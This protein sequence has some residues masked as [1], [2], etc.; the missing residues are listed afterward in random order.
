MPM[1]IEWAKDGD[2]RQA[3]HHPGAAGD[4]RVAA[5]SRRLRDLRA[6]GH[7]PGAGHRPRGRR[8]DR[9][10]V[11]ARSLRQR[12]D[13]AAFQPGEVLVA[14]ATSPD[15][16]PVMKSAAAI[17]TDRGGRTC[18]AAIVARELGV[19]AVVGADGRARRSSQTGTV[20]TVSCAE[21][22]IGSVYEGTLPSRSTR[23]AARRAAA[24]ADRDH[25]QS[26]QSRARVPHGDAAERRRRPRPHG[27]HH[28]RAH[29]RPSDGAG[30]SR[31][32][33]VGQGAGGDRAAGRGLRPSRRIT[34]SSGCPR[35]SAR[36]PRRSIP[37]R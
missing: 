26:R 34:S 12:G 6:E 21:G 16:E 7:R 19:P 9:L 4:G 2:G 35:A 28:Q 24:A 37:S 18:H 29:R 10:R 23:I 31:Q 5:P 27:V 36:S 15:W 25:G 11:G 20:V 14:E 13:L 32:G 22:E 33:R 17:V 30:P 8:E 3:L 1:D